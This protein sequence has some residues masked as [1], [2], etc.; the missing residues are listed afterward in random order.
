MCGLHLRS[1]M[2]CMGPNLSEKGGNVFILDKLEHTGYGGGGSPVSCTYDKCTRCNLG[3][4]TRI[5]KLRR[6]FVDVGGGAVM[7]RRA[8]VL[9][10]PSD[11]DLGRLAPSDRVARR[12]C[13]GR[14]PAPVCFLLAAQQALGGHQRPRSTALCFA[15]PSRLVRSKRSSSL[16]PANT[17]LAKLP[18]EALSSERRVGVAGGR[19][20]IWQ[21]LKV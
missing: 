5:W 15:F 11:V 8:G 20:H 3:T 7:C 10:R 12:P 2:K 4:W 21:G 13:S 6:S 18:R 14:G 16:C 9:S 19:R 1:G 17:T